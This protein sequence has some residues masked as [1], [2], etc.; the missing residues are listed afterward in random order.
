MDGDLAEVEPVEEVAAGV[1]EQLLRVAALEREHDHPGLA[2]R[3]GGRPRGMDAVRGRPV[4]GGRSRRGG[5]RLGLGL[6]LGL[7]RCG[8]GRPADREREPLADQPHE[9]HQRRADRARRPGEG[10]RGGEP[11]PLGVGPPGPVPLEGVDPPGHVGDPRLEG[12]EDPG[13]LLAVGLD[14]VEDLAEHVG[15]GAGVGAGVGL[16][17]RRGG[18]RGPG[19]G[20][21]PP[22]RRRPRPA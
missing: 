2:P 10:R 4:L 20:P 5:R 18:L 6:G 17:R 3:L 19:P 7:G 13:R 22:R 21:G 16:G 12:L 8:P 14:R 11:G 1:A 9:V 15:V